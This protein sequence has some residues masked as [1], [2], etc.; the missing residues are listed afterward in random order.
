MRYAGSFCGN[1]HGLC[2]NP[3]LTFPLLEKIRQGEQGSS[4]APRAP[5]FGKKLSG[6]QRAGL[7]DQLWFRS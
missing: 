2:S 5:V 1:V 3:K 6:R 4:C 7:V